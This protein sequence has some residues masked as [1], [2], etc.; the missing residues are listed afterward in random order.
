MSV[1]A[2]EI[3]KNHCFVTHTG[4][5]LWHKK[6]LSCDIQKSL[7]FVTH[8]FACFM[9][10]RKWNFSYIAWIHVMLNEFRLKMGDNLLKRLVFRMRSHDGIN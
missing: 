3:W 9:G 6:A 10:D 5:I 2:C 8:D 7:P 4:A 1:L